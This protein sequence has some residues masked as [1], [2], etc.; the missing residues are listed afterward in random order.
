MSIHY[1]NYTFPLVT[2]PQL[3]TTKSVPSCISPFCE[4]QLFSLVELFFRIYFAVVSC[5]EATNLMNICVTGAVLPLLCGSNPI[6]PSYFRCPV[7]LWLITS[8]LWYVPNQ[9]GPNFL[10]LFLYLS[11]V[12]FFHLLSSFYFSSVFSS[13]LFFINYFFF[14]LLFSFLSLAVHFFLLSLHIFL[15]VHDPTHVLRYFPYLSFLCLPLCV[16][17]HFFI[18]CL[19]SCSG[20]TG[21]RPITLNSIQWDCCEDIPDAC[22]TK[23]N[24]TID[25]ECRLLGCGAV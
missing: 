2:S 14:H 19:L 12:F 11:S 21:C 6:W 16:P 22:L 5:E 17:M 25:E 3:L 1:N 8:K 10:F 13:F 20:A 18:L 7:V 15:V 24:W 9:I 4:L 23:Q